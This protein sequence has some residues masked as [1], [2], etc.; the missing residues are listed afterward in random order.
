MSDINK[1]ELSGS[2][3]RLKAVSTK[4]GNPMATFSLRC[5]DSW[6]R[7]TTFGNLADHILANAQSGDRVALQGSLTSDR[8]QGEDGTWNNSFGVTAWAVELHGQ[9]VAYQR[10]RQTKAAPAL[11]PGDFVVRPDDPF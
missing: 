11:E 7:I 2:I 8:W 5:K 6:F 10:A 4:S 3:D 1:C 9:Q